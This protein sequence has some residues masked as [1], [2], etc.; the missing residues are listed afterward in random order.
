M[1]KVKAMFFFAL[2]CACG[3]E[4]LAY[5]GIKI[6]SPEQ[7]ALRRF[8]PGTPEPL[9]VN[10]RVF[11]SDALLGSWVTNL[12]LAWTELV[13]DQETR[14]RTVQVAVPPNAEKTYDYLLRVSSVIDDGN[15]GLVADE[16]A[17]AGFLKVAAGEK[18]QLNV[19]AHTGGCSPL[20]CQSASDCIG[21]RYCLAFECYDQQECG[22]CPAGAGCDADG[23]CSGD[24]LDDSWCTAAYRCCRGICSPHCPDW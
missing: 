3:R 4:D 24:C 1:H 10:L 23:H 16:C 17:V 21:Q 13:P 14:K 19:S 2:L 15:N 18:K 7:A 6:S 20:L 8:P 22:K 11:R 9:F 5:M 12:D